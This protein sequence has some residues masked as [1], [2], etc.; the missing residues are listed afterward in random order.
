MTE[1]EDKMLEVLKDIKLAIEELS[2]K[3]DLL[4][5]SLGEYS[6]FIRGIYLIGDHLEMITRQ[7]ELL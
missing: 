6:P 7:L 1:Y 3:T 4:D 5:G 2:D